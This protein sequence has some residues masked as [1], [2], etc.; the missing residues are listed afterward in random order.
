MFVHF[1]CEEIILDKLD[2]SN[3]KVYKLS[4]LAIIAVSGADAAQFLQ[5]QLTCDVK[6]LQPLQ[7]S[8]AAF[9]NAKGR[10]ITTTLLVRTTQSF[11]LIIPASL[12]EKVLKKLQ[13]YVLR[14]AV[15]LTAE[16]G[17]WQLFGMDFTSSVKL[18]EPSSEHQFIST[19]DK[20]FLKHP[21]SLSR[22]YCLVNNPELQ[23]TAILNNPGYS[24]DDMEWRFLEM[25]LGF[26]WFEDAQSE[27]YIPQMLNIDQLNGIS[28]NKGCYTGQEIIARTHY[29]GKAKRQLFLA[30]CSKQ[31]D[32]EISGFQIL[33]A[34]SNQVIGNV[35][36]SVAYAENIRM[37]TVLQI[38][39]A[40]AHQ[41][42]LDDTKRTAIKIIPFQQ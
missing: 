34:D 20:I 9:C 3:C 18:Q 5:G 33:G 7:S 4:H 12:L 30:E 29:L 6:A 17:N 8:V 27:L 26:P 42:V 41:L 2:N 14:S 10:V 22:Y 37:L 13:L 31:E 25:S 24:A 39:D 19:A 23:D 15:K 28:F 38:T 11:C 21:S 32:L 35:L 16:T 1:S 40:G 36:S